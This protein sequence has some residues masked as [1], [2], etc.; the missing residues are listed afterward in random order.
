MLIK[1]SLP[2]SV[3]FSPSDIHKLKAVDDISMGTL[4][5]TYHDIQHCGSPL[6]TKNVETV[7]NLAADLEEESVDHLY[8]E[9]FEMNNVPKPNRVRTAPNREL[10]PVKTELVNNALYCTSPMNFGD[11]NEEE[12]SPMYQ[13]PD[14]L[15][16]VSNKS[17]P[18]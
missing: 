16:D 14:E 11:W 2:F 9:P 12:N 1:Q 8:S 17:C 5:G 15:V 18:Y 10:P 13:N 4:D 6:D 7:I 3:F